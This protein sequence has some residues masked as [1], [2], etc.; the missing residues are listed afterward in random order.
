[1]FRVTCV[2]VREKSRGVGMI[3]S[4]VGTEIAL[5][6]FLCLA[7]MVLLV[8]TSADLLKLTCTVIHRNNSLCRLVCVLDTFYSCGNGCMCFPVPSCLHPCC[9]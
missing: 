6:V 7:Q 5:S 8:V 9:F 1:M 2:L 3:C 4:N